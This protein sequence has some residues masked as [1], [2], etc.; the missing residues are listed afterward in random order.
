MLA[1][2]AFLALS[3]LFCPA[4]VL[5]DEQGIPPAVLKA[6]NSVIRI[7][8]IYVNRK[9]KY[10]EGHAS[11]FV[12][13]PGRLVTNY[14]LVADPASQGYNL[15][16][17]KVMDGGFSKGKYKEASIIA[18][19]ERLDL[20]LIKVET[21]TD[22]DLLKIVV[23]SNA[24]KTKSP[25]NE[26]QVVFALG[27]PGIAA[28]WDVGELLRQDAEGKLKTEDLTLAEENL[29]T[30]LVTG[31]G[32]IEALTNTRQWGFK[33]ILSSQD[34]PVRIIQHGAQINPG[35]SGGPLVDRCGDVV[36]V[37]TMV[38]KSVNTV[39]EALDVSEL[40]NFLD[41]NN[42]KYQ[43]AEGSCPES[44]AAAS[45]AVAAT[46]SQPNG[47]PPS[48]VSLLAGLGLV[49]SALTGF[50]LLLIRKPSAKSNAEGDGPTPILPASVV[51][52]KDSGFCLQGMQRFK[53]LRFPLNKIHIQIGSSTS[54][55]DYAVPDQ[56]VSRHHI[57]LRNRDGQWQVVTAHE[58]L[59]PTRLNGEVVPR[60]EAR[61]LREGDVLELGEANFRFSRA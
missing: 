24:G 59:N 38:A 28:Q 42:V 46:V 35:N 55:N 17:L 53:N 37:N 22:R 61:N 25:V 19:S 20:A 14:H 29:T 60:N 41:T 48:W 32:S 27:F 2:Y 49:I 4:A 1:R 34:T 54:L 56:T 44:T 47:Q 43:K 40:A 9:G 5:A 13:A 50:A 33:G 11:G 16:E 58:T 6:K 10:I 39:N 30:P 51:T 3:I 45:Q 31:P 57:D 15:V 7:N 12:V 21:L 8:A 52:A 18:Q 23:P 36:G 26:S